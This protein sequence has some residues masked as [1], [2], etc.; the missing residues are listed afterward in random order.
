[1]FSLFTDL[2]DRLTYVCSIL[3]RTM[4]FGYVLVL[5]DIHPEMLKPRGQNFGLGFGLGLGTL[6]P[7][8]QAFG[9]GLE[10]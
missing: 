2:P 3:F 4:L 8:P 10:L 5:L 7:R 9:L 6:W 1:M